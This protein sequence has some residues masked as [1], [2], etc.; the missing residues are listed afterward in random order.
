MTRPPPFLSIG[1]LIISSRGRNI[2]SDPATEKLL[3][4]KGLIWVLVLWN[5]YSLHF[6]SWPQWGE[7]L[8][9]ATKVIVSWLS[10]RVTMMLSDHRLNTLK[11]WAKM[12]FCRVAGQWKFTLPLAYP[13]LETWKAP[14]LWLSLKSQMLQS[15]LQARLWLHCTFPLAHLQ[16]FRML[17]RP[18]KTCPTPSPLQ[19]LFPCRGSCLS[20][21]PNLLC[22]IGC[23]IWFGGIP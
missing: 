12:I 16:M 17:Q 3:L 20:A 5:C 19:S 4:K 9:F 15:S 23:M 22:E 10:N 14:P 8:D 7:Q 11:P 6:A 18:N 13:Q 21:L 1:N 2:F